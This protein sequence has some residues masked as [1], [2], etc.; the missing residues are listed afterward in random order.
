[1]TGKAKATDGSAQGTTV[2]EVGTLGIIVLPKVE[3]TL[4][5]SGA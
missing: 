4:F 1:M 5:R 2:V 3:N